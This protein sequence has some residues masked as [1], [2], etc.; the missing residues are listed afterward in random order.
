MT[1]IPRSKSDCISLGDTDRRKIIIGIA[2]GIP[3]LFAGC[4]SSGDTSNKENVAGDPDSSSSEVLPKEYHEAMS[5]LNRAYS[6]IDSLQIVEGDELVFNVTEFADSFDYREVMDLGEEAFELLSSIE[7]DGDLPG[8]TIEKLTAASRL[9]HPLAELRLIL[10]D[11]IVYGVRF[12]IA[13]QNEEFDEALTH[14]D[15]ALTALDFVDQNGSR[16]DEQLAILNGEAVDIP[17]YDHETI[18]TDRRVSDEIFFWTQ[19]SY[20]GFQ[21]TAIGGMLMLSGSVQLEEEQIRKAID[22]YGKAS[23][24]FSNAV[25]AFDAAHGQGRR[26]PQ[27]AGLFESLRCQVPKLRDG[28][29]GLEKAIEEYDQGDRE[30][31]REIANEAFL[32]LELVARRCS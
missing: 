1:G 17:R 26:L 22:Q 11:V 25:D 6:Q 32:Q 12:G 23:D 13:F 2:A 7:V 31:A 5:K 4:N 14:I 27:V 10:N 30:D 15:H 19:S 18:A 29:M 16:I 28:A 9:V 8:E 3:G 21:H 20:E 24:H